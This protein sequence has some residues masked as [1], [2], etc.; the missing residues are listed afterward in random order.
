MTP[1]KAVGKTKMPIVGGRGKAGGL[2]EMWEGTME[3]DQTAHLND[4]TP[5]S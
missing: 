3:R 5:A 1:K 2:I 4:A